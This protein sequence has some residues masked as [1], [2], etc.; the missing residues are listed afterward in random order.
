MINP[1]WILISNRISEFFDE[2]T[3]MLMVFVGSVVPLTD[4]NLD[5]QRQKPHP[6]SASRSSAAAKEV[7]QN[8][9]FFPPSPS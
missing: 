1:T 5:L 9:G 4:Y 3:D 8:G 6:K 7:R 2:F